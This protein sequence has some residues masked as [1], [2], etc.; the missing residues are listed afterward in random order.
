MVGKP[1]LD[2]AS[3]MNVAAIPGASLTAEPGNHPYE[4]PAKFSEPEKFFAL[5]TKQVK[6]PAA[7]KDIVGLLN[8][9][10]TA[11]TIA[12]GI[13]MSAFTEGHVSPDVAELVKEP[14]V[15]VI[16][17]IGLENGVE[18][19]NIVNELP[20]PSMSMEDSYGLMETVNPEKFDREME[21]IPE[22]DPR[23]DDMAMIE[24]DEESE[25]IPEGFITREGSA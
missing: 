20:E 19:M 6:Q 14:L 1:F 25:G 8:V 11:E 10:L 9:G 17:R 21:Q 12:S 3:P 4:K 23:E 2:N 18:D 22:Y 24:E 5:I 13:V 16:V 15:R 7:S